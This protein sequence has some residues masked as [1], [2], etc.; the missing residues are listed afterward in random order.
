MG[1]VLTKRPFDNSLDGLRAL[2]PLRLLRYF[3]RTKKVRLLKLKKKEVSSDTLNSKKLSSDTHVLCIPRA[4]HQLTVRSSPVHTTPHH[5]ILHHISPVPS[6]PLHSTPHYTTLHYTRHNVGKLTQKKSNLPA[7]PD[8][9]KSI[10][11][12]PEKLHNRTP[13]QPNPARTAAT[14]PLHLLK[15]GNTLT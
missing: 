2:T 3:A 13:T 6:S 7:S 12:S 15:L 14:L 10:V 9:L 11:H 5:T 8:L 4:S 1:N